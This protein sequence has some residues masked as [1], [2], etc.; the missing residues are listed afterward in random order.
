MLNVFPTPRG[1]K[2]TPA[3]LYAAGPR[4]AT[5]IGVPTSLAAQLSASGQQIPPPVMVSA[6]IDTGASLTAVDLE[7][8]KQLALEPIGETR[9]STPS[10]PKA[11][12]GIYAVSLTFPQARETRVTVDPIPVAGCQLKSQGMGM[13]LGR[14]FL[15]NVVLIYNGPGGFFTVAY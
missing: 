10:D 2:F 8:L 15:N 4:I 11:K 13:L 7:I 12:A 5:Q 9:L 1:A 3:L 14:D 6:L